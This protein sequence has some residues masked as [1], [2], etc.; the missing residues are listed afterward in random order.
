MGQNIKIFKFLFACLLVVNI[1]GQELL[2][3]KC[4]FAQRHQI[5]TCIDLDFKNSDLGN[6]IKEDTHVLIIKGSNNLEVPSSY[7]KNKNFLHITSYQLVENGVVQIDPFAFKEMENLRY[8]K[9]SDNADWSTLE[10]ST[11][12]GLNK[13]ETLSIAN[14]SI[15]T[16]Q[17]GA[18]QGL[19]DLDV[20]ELTHNKFQALPSSIVEDLRSATSVFLYH[21]NIQIL[22]SGCFEGLSK[23]QLLDITY[24][25]LKTI[26]TSTFNH[27][28]KLTDLYLSFNQIETIEGKF[29]LTNLKFLYL[30]H[31]KLRRISDDVFKACPKTM[32]IDLSHNEI[33]SVADNAFSELTSLDHVNLGH[34]KVSSF[35]NLKFSDVN[36]PHVVD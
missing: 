24:N 26:Q 15:K 1:S 17:K 19:T 12:S 9:I 6:L 16:L 32:A 21:N 27:L 34:N 30:H 20:L 22:E 10:S 35:N 8:L 29:A 4:D 36:K 31:N 14:N 33:E 25:N 11:F 3:N 18:F 2:N 7:H 13:L 23:V 5:L 28:T